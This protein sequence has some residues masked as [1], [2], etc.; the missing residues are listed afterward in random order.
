MT[1][2]RLDEIVREMLL[3]GAPRSAP[4][5]L[6]ERVA[7]VPR[8]LGYGRAR[9]SRTLA[10]AA[11]VTTVAVLGGTLL[12]LFALRSAT[13]GPQPTAA[14][15]PTTATVTPGPTPRPAAA[16][17]FRIANGNLPVRAPDGTLYV[18]TGP[19]TSNGQAKVYALD[20]GG[21]VKQGW[22][23]APAGIVGFSRP[24]LGADGT[25]YAAGV[26]YGD[27]AG[28]KIFALDSAG[29]PKAGWSPQVEAA[30]TA[31][32]AGGNLFVAPDGDLIV[33]TWKAPTT[34][35][36]QAQQ[37]AALDSHG[38][39]VA[40]WPVTLPGYLSCGT[41]GCAV[42][43]LA[44]DP[45]G[46]VYLE[47][48]PALGF[49]KTF[50]IVAYAPDGTMRPGWPVRVPGEGFTVAAGG[51][52]YAWGVETDG[53]QLP[54]TTPLRI[55]RT[56]FTAFDPSG[57]VRSGWPLAI[58]GPA[59]PPYVAADGTLYIVTGAPDSVARV[60]RIG[61]G[62]QVHELFTLPPTEQAWSYGFGE[63]NPG[64]LA[65]PTIGP[66]G[67]VYLQV[68]KD[69]SQTQGV[70]AIAP[71]GSVPS[72][73]P[74]WFSAGAAF[75]SVAPFTTGS[76]GNVQPP[77]IAPDGTVFVAVRQPGGQGAV[78]GLGPDGAERQGWPFVEATSAR[79]VITDVRVIGE[80]VVVTGV[81]P[82][83]GRS[84]F[85]VALSLD[86]APMR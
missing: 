38:S 45:G 79:T 46:T 10:L 41:T 82:F 47:V 40:G 67:T 25:V 56:D 7:A 14:S 6:R 30:P 9:R 2:N 16:W 43:A 85:V 33:V 84:T 39:L 53:G 59:S 86:G 44:F 18:S 74:I 20:A 77:A 29:D 76:G 32:T 83:N 31:L 19:S 62:G 55:V 34:R 22:P 11:S 24:V 8:E 71:D 35:S 63:G 54:S 21:H 57:Q 26:R 4:P 65:S 75:E 28:A 49:S 37:L 73:W 72:G 27:N 36:A 52:I 51:T 61:T 78:L 13:V 23:Y 66:A 17:P 5:E 48:G 1:G 81:T 80:V 50:D 70:L 12:G 3:E 64:R 58:P 69:N 68:L 15:K 60:E 42:P